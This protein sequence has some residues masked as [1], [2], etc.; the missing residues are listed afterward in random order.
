MLSL[1]CRHDDD[2]YDDDVYNINDVENHIHA[3]PLSLVIINQA[4]QWLRGKNTPAE[5]AVEAKTVERVCFLISIC[6]A[7]K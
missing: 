4:I 6:F 7:K 2:F 5:L 3:V 1:C